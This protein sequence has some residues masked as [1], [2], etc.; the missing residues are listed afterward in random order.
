MVDDI[1]EDEIGQYSETIQKLRYL[2]DLGHE[3][4][5]VG[6]GALAHELQ[7]RVQQEAW[8]RN[9]A[10]T[11]D[12]RTNPKTQLMELMRAQQQAKYTPESWEKWHLVR[13][14]LANKRIEDMAL[15]P[16]NFEFQ[17]GHKAAGGE[18]LHDPI[19]KGVEYFKERLKI[20]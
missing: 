3:P 4:S 5:Q 10:L 11:K 16:T 15:H 9:R 6:Y 18:G 2:S 12:F 1:P 8:E 13:P 7:A 17:T 19:G 14:D 20:K